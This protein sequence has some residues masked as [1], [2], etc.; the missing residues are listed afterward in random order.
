MLRIKITRESNQIK[1]ITFI[2][3]ANYNDYGND[4]VCAATSATMLCTV[5][6]IFSINNDAIKVEKDTNLTTID[7][8]SNDQIIIK[9]IDN[10][11]R[12]LKSLE[13]QYP[14]NIKIK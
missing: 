12:C 4:I 10:M 9:L 13:Q 8:L 14:K 6:A 11:V 5:N 7:V 1:K 2:G 3:H